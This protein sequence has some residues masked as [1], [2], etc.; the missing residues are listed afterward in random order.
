MS[1]G[2]RIKSV[3]GDL[4][5]KDFAQLLGVNASTVQRWEKDDAAPGGEALKIIHESLRVDLNWLLS[6][7]GAPYP[8]EPADRSPADPRLLDSDNYFLV[9][10]ARGAASGGPGKVVFD[11]ID[12]YFP[13]KKDFIVKI[14]GSTQEKRRNLYLIEVRG[15]SML[16]TI[17]EGE[18]ILLN[19][20]EEQRTA[21]SNGGVY[22]VRNPYGDIEIKRLYTVTE[23]GAPKLLLRPDN[24][25]LKQYAVDITPGV[26]LSEIIIGRVVWVGK[27]LL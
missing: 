11:A 22:A 1:L 25:S 9:G 12:D 19:C 2:S 6:G 24:P 18:L 16:P 5:R 20:N 23:D 3:R 7:T 13:F 10:K 15:N 4:S 26:K 17:T 14:G 21:V 8:A 27:E